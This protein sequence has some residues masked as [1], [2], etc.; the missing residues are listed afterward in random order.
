MYICSEVF[1]VIC[2]SVICDSSPSLHYISHLKYDYMQD[3]QRVHGPLQNTF[4]MSILCWLFTGSSDVW[5]DTE[6]SVHLIPDFMLFSYQYFQFS[7]P[8][9]T[10]KL[11]LV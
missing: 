2:D 1:H 7:L 8:L 11:L 10:K 6:L 9:L 5:I 4:L 3:M